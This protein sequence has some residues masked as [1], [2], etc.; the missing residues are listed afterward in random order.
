MVRWRPSAWLCLLM[1]T[2]W[3]H[4][5]QIRGNHGQHSTPGSTSVSRAALHTS[6]TTS[7]YSR[8]SQLSCLVR[9]CVWRCSRVSS[10]ATLVPAS[11][12]SY[13]STC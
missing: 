1:R 9:A 3:S 2:I 11:L 8:A 10:Q 7:Q 12:I 4:D 6:V 13:G 5:T